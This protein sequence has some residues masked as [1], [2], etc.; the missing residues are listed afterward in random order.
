MQERQ[1]IPLVGL[2]IAII[3]IFGFF[4]QSHWQLVRFPWFYKIWV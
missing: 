3:V 2:F 1:S 4:Q